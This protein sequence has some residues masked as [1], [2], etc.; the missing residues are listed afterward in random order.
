MMFDFRPVRTYESVPR[1]SA[2]FIG[3]PFSSSRVESME[4]GEHR[5]YNNEPWKP[6]QR[7][8]NSA[9]TRTL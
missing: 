7:S 4:M 8:G 1:P 6:N 5:L 3:F 2:H 9:H